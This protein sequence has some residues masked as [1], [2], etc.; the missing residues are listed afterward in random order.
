MA[1]DAL[2]PVMN[3]LCINL[4]EDYSDYVSSNGHILVRVRK[5]PVKYSYS[6]ETA[7]TSFIIPARIVSILQR[8]LPKTGNVDI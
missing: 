2:R 1:Q 7:V 4:T 6:N 5:K 8:V 3:G